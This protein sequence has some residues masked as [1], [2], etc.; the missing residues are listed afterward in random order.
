M[1][2][3][4]R[5]PKTK[6]KSEVQQ[7]AQALERLSVQYIPVTDVTPNSYNPNRQGEHEFDLLKRSINE[8]GF[9]QPVVAVKDPN[10][11]SKVV[12][13]DG[14]H[15][16]RAASAL[17]YKEIPVVVVPMTPEQARIATLRHNKAKGSHDLELEAQ[18]LRD[19]EKL[20]ALDWA[21]ESLMMDDVEI[22]RLLEDVPAPVALASEDYGNA[23]EPAKAH[24]GSA[25]TT[26]EYSEAPDGTHATAM[27]PAAIQA[28][29]AREQAV[30]AAQTEAEKEKAR[31]D[32]DVYRLVVVFSG[33]EAS[34]VRQ[35]LGTANPAK[36]VLDLCMKSLGATPAGAS[37]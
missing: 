19:L 21:Q 11:P 5:K 29:R 16:W 33:Q 4:P 17:G 13:V 34:F 23:W 7:K 15:R 1:S 8:D 35:V 18:V 36:A 31:Q 24:E 30:A 3:T 26:A 14:E 27:T 37:P 2:S 28:V 25:A 22:Q 6:G 20:G 9:T 32:N 12:I 10:D